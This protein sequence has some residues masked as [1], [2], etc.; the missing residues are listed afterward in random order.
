M[1]NYD[2]ELISNQIKSVS[3]QHQI[4]FGLLDMQLHVLVSHVAKNVILEAGLSD[5]GGRA[6]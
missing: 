6:Y 5:F 4:G 2:I 3:D 1:F